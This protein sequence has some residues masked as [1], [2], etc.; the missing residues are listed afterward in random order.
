MAR[1]A[2]FAQEA[3]VMVRRFRIYG[4]KIIA[5]SDEL[6]GGPHGDNALSVVS[7]P[8]HY[9]G[10]YTAV[11]DEHQKRQRRTLGRFIPIRMRRDCSP[12]GWNIKPVADIGFF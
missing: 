4:V 5:Y 9:F 12:P 1:F 3:F 8:A 2:E 11:V 7:Q 6:F 10:S